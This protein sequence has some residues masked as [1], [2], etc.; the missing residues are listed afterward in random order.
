M[1]FVDVDTHYFPIDCYQ[2]LPEPFRSL[3]PQYTWKQYTEKPQWW[4]RVNDKTS[5]ADNSALCVWDDY[6]GQKFLCDNNGYHDIDIF[7]GGV[8]RHLDSVKPGLE[9]R[10]S[11]DKTH[12]GPFHGGYR[13]NLPSAMN[14]EERKKSLA[15]LGIDKNVLLPYS[16]ILGLNYRIDHVLA[17]AL[18]TAYNNTIQTDCKDQEQ[19]WP[20]IWL[21]LQ[22]PNINENISLIEQGLS[23]GAVGL[24]LGEYF[25]YANHC[26]GQSWGTC[27]WMEP[28]WAHADKYQYPIFFHVNDCW[29]DNLKW[30]NSTL[31]DK[32]I[33]INWAKAHKNLFNL[34]KNDDK[35][36]IKLH[37]LSFASLITEGVLDRYPNLRLVWLERGIDW[38][39]PL[40]TRLSKLLDRDCTPYLKNWSFNAEPEWPDFEINSKKIGYDRLLFV[41]DYPHLDLSGKNQEFDTEL[42][43]SL[44]IDTCD[45]EKIAN[46]NA[47]QL[48][49]KTGFI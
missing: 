22:N 38:V 19:F 2:N 23:N 11:H 9:R 42:I 45:K 46:L 37:E 24:Q 39:L 16:F 18:A 14:L 10:L 7:P 31:V 3:A 32:S 34:I 21:P 5:N 4:D 15:K 28:L 40:L 25:T 8:S 6:K 29:Y 12:G 26:L 43:K 47:K 30:L 1:Q 48:L 17:T 20:L 49:N 44:N 27:S 35:T 41:T 36:F 13:Y 33:K